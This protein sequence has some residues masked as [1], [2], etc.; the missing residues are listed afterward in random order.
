MHVASVYRYDAKERDM[1]PAPGGGTSAT[2]SLEE[3]QEADVWAENIW[4][5]VLS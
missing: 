4:G 3:G 1:K 5:D 2:P